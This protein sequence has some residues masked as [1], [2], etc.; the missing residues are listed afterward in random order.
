MTKLEGIV[1]IKTLTNKVNKNQLAI[2]NLKQ[3]NKTILARINNYKFELKE[4]E[5]TI[6]IKNYEELY[7]ISK[8]GRIWSH[9]R[10]KKIYINRKTN[11]LY[12]GKW[13]KT[14]KN[15]DGYLHIHLSKNKKIKHFKIHRLVA[16]AHIPNPKNKPYINH[17][18]GNK[19]DNR[20]ENLRW[21]TALEYVSYSK[22]KGNYA[23]K[24]TQEQINEIRQNHIS[25]D[26]YKRKPWKKY[27]ISLSTYYKALDKKFSYSET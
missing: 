9:S 1:L 4:I 3:K 10:S 12:L 21:C 15:T 25:K 24:L 26:I 8:D 5:K 20:I 16:Q 23:L 19:I 27:K 2:K 6:P 11:K 17:I 18:N 14:T 13:L 22:I 7:S